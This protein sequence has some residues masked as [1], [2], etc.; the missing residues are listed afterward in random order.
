MGI[1]SAGAQL[2]LSAATVTGPLLLSIFFRKEI[3]FE[4][5]AKR[6][7]LEELDREKARF[8]SSRDMALKQQGEA[9]QSQHSPQELEAQRRQRDYLMVTDS[10]D[11]P[12]Y[13]AQ[14]SEQCDSANERTE[15]IE[16]SDGWGDQGPDPAVWEQHMMQVGAIVD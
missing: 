3:Q 12:V 14:A 1:A 15:L 6:K 16:G 4:R 11:A 9:D 2:G 10:Y 8:Q 13:R 5:D 7:A